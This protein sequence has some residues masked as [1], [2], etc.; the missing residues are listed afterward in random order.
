MNTENKCGCAGENMCGNCAGVG[1][2]GMMVN[3]CNY[4]HKILKKLLIFLVMIIIFNLGMKI[5]EV[6]GM[7]KMNM[8]YNS[9][10]S[11]QTQNSNYAYPMMGG[12]EGNS[13][14]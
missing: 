9:Q 3:G 1:K 6:K 8:Y 12:F 13:V 2:C 10:K 14:N 4:K 7:L 5:G 11:I